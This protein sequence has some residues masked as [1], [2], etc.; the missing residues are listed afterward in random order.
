MW[1][2]STGAGGGYNNKL[3]TRVGLTV[4]VTSEQRPEEDGEPFLLIS[5][6]RAIQTKECGWRG[7]S[8][9]KRKGSG[10]R[11]KKVLQ[12][13]GSFEDLCKEFCFYF[14]RVGKP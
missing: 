5:G 3:L 9:R 4:K 8:Q 12:N 7:V 10:Q 11:D 2:E 1:I 13:V 6:R 14:E